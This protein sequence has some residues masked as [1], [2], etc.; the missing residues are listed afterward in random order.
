MDFG[1]V[2]GKKPNW[3]FYMPDEPI[4]FP[5]NPTYRFAEGGRSGREL[6]ITPVDDLSELS[7][8]SS[9]PGYSVFPSSELSTD[10]IPPLYQSTNSGSQSFSPNLDV[11]YYPSVE[12]PQLP[13]KEGS[14]SNYGSVNAAQ[15]ST[16]S[17]AS[18]VSREEEPVLSSNS[19]N[20]PQAA[21]SSPASPSY[22]TDLDL[23]KR[24]VTAQRPR[25]QPGNKVPQLPSTQL[26]MPQE[27]SYLFPS[28]NIV[29]SKGG[30]RRGRKMYS[31]ARYSRTFP[32]PAPIGLKEPRKGNW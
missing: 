1:L 26:E 19:A 6:Q 17:S 9:N 24:K 25:F 11:L 2:N 28:T 5:L 23:T 7:T 30:Y 22:G 10:P 31:K 4:T 3:E 32:P 16:W 18:Y 12:N 21:V 29:Q 14:P 15:P 27:V 20:W 13:S 8:Q